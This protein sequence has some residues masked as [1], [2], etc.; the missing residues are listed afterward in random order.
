VY[1]QEQKGCWSHARHWIHVPATICL[2]AF[3][4]FC[5]RAKIFFDDHQR[6]ISLYLQVPRSYIMIFYI[7]LYI[8]PRYYLLACCTRRG[9]EAAK[10]S[11]K[12]AKGTRHFRIRHWS[13]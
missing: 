12:R 10:Y 4:I 3:F 8:S 6:E 1:I 9:T 11:Q 13:S 5:G 7:F 2:R